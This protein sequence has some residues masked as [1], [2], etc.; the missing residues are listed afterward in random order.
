[1]PGPGGGRQMAKAT[2]PNWPVVRLG[3]AYREVA[4]SRRLA[5]L[6]SEASAD[7]FPSTAEHLRHLASYVLDEAATKYNG[8]R[9]GGGL[10]PDGDGGGLSPD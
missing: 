6:S 5:K 3:Q 4:L 7:G 9:P 8:L 2:D 10:R 1:M